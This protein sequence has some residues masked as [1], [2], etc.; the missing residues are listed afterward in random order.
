[1]HGVIQTKL[2]VFGAVL[3]SVASLCAM[4]QVKKRKAVDVF[5]AKNSTQRKGV[6]GAQP[7]PGITTI[8]ALE[9]YI[10]VERPDGTT[11]VYARDSE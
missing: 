4:E 5:R 6:V 7:R 11:A 8:V 9:G 2:L 3:I 1:M 10:L